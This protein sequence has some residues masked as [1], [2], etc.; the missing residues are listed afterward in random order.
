MVQMCFLNIIL[1]LE[2]LKIAVRDTLRNIERMAWHE[3]FIPVEIHADNQR[4]AVITTSSAT[5]KAW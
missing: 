5:S 4:R 2:T 1:F 3:T